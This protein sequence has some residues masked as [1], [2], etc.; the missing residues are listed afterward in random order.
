[1]ASVQTD[2]QMAKAKQATSKLNQTLIDRARSSADTSFL[3]S[4]VTGGGIVVGRF[5]QLFLL[6][7]NQGKKQPKE[8]AQAAWSVLASQNQ[9]LVKEGK[10]IESAEGNLEEL[11][12]Q[13]EEF[14]LKNLPILKAL[15]IA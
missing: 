15:G 12:K 7:M 13:A 6:A 1:M 8:W 11:T 14:L 2:E 9:R 3:A 5:Q 4:P 10:T